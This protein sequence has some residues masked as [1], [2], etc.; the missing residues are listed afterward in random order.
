VFHSN[1]YRHI[2]MNMSMNFSIHNNN[3]SL[4]IPYTGKHV[5]L[6][7]FGKFSVPNSYKDVIQ[8]NA[9]IQ[10]IVLPDKCKITINGVTHTNVYSEPSASDRLSRTLKTL[11]KSGT[12]SRGKSNSQLYKI[13]SSNRRVIMGFFINMISLQQIGGSS[14]LEIS[15]EAMFQIGDIMFV[16]YI[17]YSFVDVVVLDDCVRIQFRE[18]LDPV[19]DS[20]LVKIIQSCKNNHSPEDMIDYCCSLPLFYKQVLDEIHIMMLSVTKD[21]SLRNT[22]PSTGL[23]VTHQ[24]RATSQSPRCWDPP[25]QTAFQQYL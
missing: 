22:I 24:R 15:K 16:G 8:H 23:Y 6:I 13:Y 7:H 20:F 12:K 4:S 11:S 25:T 14:T 3:Q 18:L 9:S 21:V 1:T 2:P 5:S 10:D 17:L 19:E